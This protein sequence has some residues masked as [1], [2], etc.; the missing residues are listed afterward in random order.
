M[1]G[2]PSSV[3]TEDHCG[4][5][6]VSES[7]K[8]DDLVSDCMQIDYLQQSVTPDTF[9]TVSLGLKNQYFFCVID[10]CL[11]EMWSIHLLK[12]STL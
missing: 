3:F 5:W 11:A 6:A 7:I 8:T 9:Y 1:H 4:R 12:L 10:G 2:P